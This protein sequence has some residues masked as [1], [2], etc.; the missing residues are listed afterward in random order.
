MAENWHGIA[1]EVES[2][3]RSV[4]ETDAGYPIVIDTGNR[5]GVT[6]NPWTPAPPAAGYVQ[7]WGIQDYNQLKDANGAL[8]DQTRHTVIVN[9]TSGVIPTEDMFLALGVTADAAN[10]DADWIPILAVR[11][12]APVGVAVLYE[13]DLVR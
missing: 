2:A 7:F 5:S 8:T 4:G 9:A 10:E 1:A 11:P 13:I 12:L 3:L 6:P